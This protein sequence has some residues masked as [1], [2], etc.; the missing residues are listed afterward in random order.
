MHYNFVL[1][2]VNKSLSIYKNKEIPELETNALKEALVIT[3]EVIQNLEISFNKIKPNSSA[4]V[5]DKFSPRYSITSQQ[6]A[7]YTKVCFSWL[8]E[9]SRLRKIPPANC[10]L[11]FVDSVV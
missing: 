7:A 11:L 3:P 10:L 2:R 5:K 1:K 8:L 9:F 6:D 4:E